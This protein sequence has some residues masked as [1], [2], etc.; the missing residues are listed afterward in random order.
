VPAG[1]ALDDKQLTEQQAI[2]LPP[3]RLEIKL[4]AM[5]PLLSS[6]IREMVR[7]APLAALVG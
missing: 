5:I 7:R 4:K 2:V 1:A 3:T 6:Q